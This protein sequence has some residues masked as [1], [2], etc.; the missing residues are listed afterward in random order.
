MYFNYMAKITS[1]FG[2]VLC[3]LVLDSCR[4][5]FKGTSIDPSVNTFYVDVF[6]VDARNAPEIIG[7]DF[8][9]LFVEKIRRESRLD[10][11]DTDP[12]IEFKG[13]ISRYEVTYEAPQPGETA[14]FNRLNLTIK[15]EYIDYKKEDAGWKQSFP[16]FFDFPN[17]QNLIDIQDEAIEAIY[18][19]LVED[20]FN[21][22]FTNW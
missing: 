18:E 19:Q 16:F 10:P 5:G 21:K 22:A 6:K 9:N 15:V 8:T 1:F 12:D 2:L 7:Q 14:A 17:N 11:V 4:Y 3:F 20:I 13:S